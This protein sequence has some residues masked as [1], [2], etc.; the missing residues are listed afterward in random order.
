MRF[1]QL[2][3]ALEF[4]IDPTRQTDQAPVAPYGHNPEVGDTQSGRRCS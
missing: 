2:I 3:A 4:V 1:H